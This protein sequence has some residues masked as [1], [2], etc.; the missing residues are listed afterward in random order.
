VDY[1]TG[2]PHLKWG[3]ETKLHKYKQQ[4]YCYKLL[5][6]SSHTFAD[7]SVTKGR[8]EFI[9]PDSYGKIHSLEVTF[10]EKEL[11]HIKQL[12]QA[13]WQAIHALD[14]PKLDGYSKDL[15]GTLSF[16]ADLLEKYNV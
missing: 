15:K 4:L 9:E 11:A 14:F 2:K 13:V 3:S 16:E 6:E 10:D 7:Y 1:K 5:V 12:M 8:L